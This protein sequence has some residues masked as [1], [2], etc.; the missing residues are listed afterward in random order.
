M[1]CAEQ[2][3]DFS[4]PIIHLISKDMTLK[5]VLFCAVSVLDESSPASCDLHQ[6]AAATP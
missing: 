1:V 5:T 6:S 4:L 3:L 2:R